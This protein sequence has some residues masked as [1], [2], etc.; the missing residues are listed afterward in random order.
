M[1]RILER[2]ISVGVVAVDAGDQ[3][4]PRYG[5]MFNPE[6]G[7]VIT[8]LYAEWSLFTTD[9]DIEAFLR[10]GEPKSPFIPASPNYRM[11]YG[12]KAGSFCPLANMFDL[13]SPG[14]RFTHRNF[15]PVSI[16]RPL[17]S[18]DD[19]FKIILEGKPV[20]MRG[21]LKL[22]FSIKTRPFNP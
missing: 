8:E 3:S 14:I 10:Q 19:S 15:D 16:I 18:P 22:R 7:C 5:F 12:L 11:F 1:A 9:E 6:K 20:I 21:D 17:G 2:M 4:E 13:D